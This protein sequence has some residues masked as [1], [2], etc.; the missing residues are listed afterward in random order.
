ML[1]FLRL[2]LY[3]SV[4]IFAAC[5]DNCNECTYNETLGMSD[6]TA[7]KCKLGYYEYV[8]ATLDVLEN[9]KM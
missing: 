3:Y 6:C 9:P 5:P 4:Y 2:T 7:S 1:M 8:Y